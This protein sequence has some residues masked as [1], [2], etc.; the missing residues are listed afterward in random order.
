M[1]SHRIVS[2]RIV[3]YRSVSYRIVSYRIVLC[4]NID[5]AE[6]ARTICNAALGADGNNPLDRKNDR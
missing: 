4:G 5:I 3:S 1:V 2:F 6:L